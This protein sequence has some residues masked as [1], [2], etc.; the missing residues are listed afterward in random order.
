MPVPGGLYLARLQKK[1]LS[2]YNY[3]AVILPSMLTID[4]STFELLKK[5]MNNG[6]LVLSMGKPARN[7]PGSAT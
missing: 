7:V 4:K 2:P 1:R 5:L 3:K 6:G